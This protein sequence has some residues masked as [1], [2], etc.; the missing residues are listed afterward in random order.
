MVRIL[1]DKKLDF[2][3]V[4]IRP[5]QSE[6]NSR[7]QVNLER[8]FT[9][10]HSTKSWTG[11]PVLS[12]NMDSTGTFEVYDIL[13]KY[14][15]LTALHKFYNK[16]DCLNA[17]KERDNFNSSNIIIST[18]ISNDDFIKLKS[19]MKQL[20]AH[21]I[22]IDVANGHMVQL[23]DFCKKVRNEF[24]DKIIIAGNV[25]SGEMTEKLINEGGVDVVKVG[26]GSGC[27][28]GN[29]KILMNTG[30]YK[31]ISDIE[32]GEKVINREGKIVTVL[33]KMNKGYRNVIE[34][35]TSNWN[36]KTIVTNDHRYWTLCIEND[37]KKYQWK[38][39]G[40][41]STND[42][43]LTPKIENNNETNKENNNEKISKICHN[44]DK[45]LITNMK[46]LDEKV[47]VWDIEVDCPTHSFIANNAI[48]HNSA[49]IT[50]LK[51][52]V[53][54]PQL[55][56][57][58]ECAEVAHK[59]GGYI[60]SDGGITCPADMAKAFCAGADFVMCGGVF[61]GHDENPGELIEENG[62]QYKLFYGMSS[63][64]AMK[65][66]YGKMN[67]YRSS[68]G[69]V[70]K[71]KYK[72]ALEKTVKDYLGGLRS[73]CT[74]INSKNIDNMEK[75][76]EFVLVNHQLNTSLVR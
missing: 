76:T 53:G 12:A 73:C 55:S 68:E 64:H 57:I 46:K 27:F 66:H 36:G 45:S 7:S 60:I 47:E 26:I 15:M 28:A 6:L 71:V 33:N 34:I 58:I 29:T 51:A 40:E 31:N 32:M 18:G 42:Y 14:N 75:N 25:V 30:E 11:I 52:G 37:N 62:N 48:V 41:Y 8:T 63:E 59:N 3:D 35:E 13:N 5:Q 23:I 39:I 50:R 10:K 69:R 43:I 1:P 74:Y 16:E 24:P 4:L 9:F 21:W 61:S 17:K 54:V 2:Q 38:K 20:D 70:L 22:C 44:Y 49:C 72:G 67:S 19:N 56:A 65:K